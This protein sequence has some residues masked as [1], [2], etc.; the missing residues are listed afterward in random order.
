MLTVPDIH[1]RCAW[2]AE[3]GGLCT[4]CGAS[5]SLTRNGQTETRDMK[6]QQAGQA[7]P[8][9]SSLSK[10]APEVSSLEQQPD[11]RSD[12]AESSQV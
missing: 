3:Y 1:A 8:S 6:R 2:S 10:A 9:K 4:Q 11:A 12:V 7:G 5:V